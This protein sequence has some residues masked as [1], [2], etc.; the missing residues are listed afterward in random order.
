MRRSRWKYKIFIGCLPIITLVALPI[1]SLSQATSVGIVN[2]FRES[3][4]SSG[5]IKINGNSAISEQTITS[6]SLIETSLSE[7]KCTINI[8]KVGRLDFGSETKMNLAFDDNEIFGFLSNGSVTI[9]AQPT[10]ILKIQTKDGLIKVSNQNQENTVVIDF[11]QGKTRVK[12]LAGSALLNKTLISSG[13][14]FTVG[15]QNIEEVDSTNR[16]TLFFYLFVPIEITILSLL[17]SRSDFD[18]YNSQTN[19]GPRK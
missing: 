5:V 4:T 18:I 10:T 6:P 15:D 1:I 3:A 16:S 17:G 7:I 13:Q 8:N 2:I 9:Y 11:A 19:V 12:T 14:Y